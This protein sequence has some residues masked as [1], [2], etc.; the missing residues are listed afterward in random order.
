MTNTALNS[1][2][3]ALADAIDTLQ[4]SGLCHQD[5]RFEARYLLQTLLEC[6]R[7]YL[8]IHA[9]QTLT[10]SIASCFAE[11]INRRAKGEPVAYITGERG[12]WRYQFFT[13]PD[14]LIPRPDTELLVETAL[15]LIEPNDAPVISD[16]GTGTG[17]IGLCL[18]AER[19]DATVFLVDLSL[20]A[21]KLAAKNQRY[22][23]QQTDHPV[24]AHGIQ[25]NWLD[26]FRDN[27]LDMLVSNPPYID[28]NDPHLQQG[29][30]RFEP[31][32][33]LTAGSAGFADFERIIKQAQ[34]CLKPG[35]WLVFE[36][37]ATQGAGL[38]ER[39][40]VAGFCAIETRSDLA[41]N[42]RVTLGR[43]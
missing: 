12:F 3:S 13:T 32:S 34:A 30:L 7:S 31:I 15:T 38:R 21:L 39:L 8:I 10:A 9:E 24:H 16:L 1:I 40:N 23:S 19:P 41:G 25:S 5:A 17:V 37:G 22:L 43:K 42:P 35:G 29:D 2:E 33:A 20:A 14:A 18:A 6:D 36:H 26:C 27:Q 11:W 4:S 28:P